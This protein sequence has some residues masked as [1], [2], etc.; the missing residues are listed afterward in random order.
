M[1]GPA[2]DRVHILIVD[3][4]P[5][6]LDV[7]RQLLE[8]EPWEIAIATSGETTL[9]VVSR[10]VPD[11][12]LLDIM[13]PGIDGIETCRR[14]RA[15]AGCEDV[16]VIFVTADPSVLTEGFAAGGTD[17]LTKPVRAD[18]LMCRVRNHLGTRRL[19]LALR[20]ELL[21]RESLVRLGQLVSEV[22][23]EVSTPLGVCVTAATTLLGMER[24]FAARL[25]AGSLSHADLEHFLARIHEAGDMICRNIEDA[26][27]LM[28]DF[29]DLATDE[30]SLRQR[31][32]V[33]ADY[34]RKVID[35]LGPTLRR[36]GAHVEVDIAT[37]TE[38][39]TMPGAVG[40]ILRNL[41][42]NSV[43]HG[44]EG[45]RDGRINICAAPAGDGWE[46]VYRD[47][48]CGIAAE[49]QSRLFDKFFTTRADRGGSGIG[50]HVIKTLAE[51]LGGTLTLETAPGH[52]VCFTFRFPVAPPTL[53][54]T[55]SA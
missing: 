5:A 9:D 45:R 21:A 40:Q 36:A 30:A 16:P 12:I 34:V 51:R 15:M 54:G 37:D 50:T 38:V 17:Y 18:E 23:H 22:T 35:N 1:P 10:V 28:Q 53:G 43:V 8:E 13:L 31:R 46:L 7:M 49:H 32:I 19:V 2:E 27:Q 6:N 25:R 29:K 4:N 26:S 42:V 33:L 11:V 3:D 14:L 44:F 47:N 20:R 41:V 55:G 48:G 24:D 52:G 39:L